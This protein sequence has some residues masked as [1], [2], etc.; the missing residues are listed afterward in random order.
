MDQMS[1]KGTLESDMHSRGWEV[2]PTKI[3]EASIAVKFLE[4]QRPGV[5]QE[6]PFKIED[7]V[8]S[9]TSHHEKGNMSTG[10]SL[11]DLET[12]KDCFGSYSK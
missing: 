9:H 4:H 7:K 10:R 2:N 8:L 6:I 1:R 3:Q 5:Y 12:R 11:G